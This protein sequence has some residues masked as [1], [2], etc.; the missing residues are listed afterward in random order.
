M[1]DVGL[2]EVEG[3]SSGEVLGVET[4]EDSAVHTIV[5]EGD[6]PGNLQRVSPSHW[7]F[8][9]PEMLVSQ[10]GQDVV[11][12][13][14]GS[15]EAGEAVID[16]DGSLAVVHSCQVPM[17]VVADRKEDQLKFKDIVGA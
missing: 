8:E 15:A 16:G 14:S 2:G 3:G 13:V 4:G 1:A 5:L 12:S 11:D 17:L 7:S 9:E 6:V 10:K